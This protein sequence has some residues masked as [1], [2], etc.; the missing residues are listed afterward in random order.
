MGTID[1]LDYEARSKNA[2][3]MHQENGGDLKSHVEHDHV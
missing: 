3:R 2:L 1:D